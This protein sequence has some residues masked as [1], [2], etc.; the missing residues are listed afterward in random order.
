MSDSDDFEG[1]GFSGNYYDVDVNG[2]VTFGRNVSIANELSGDGS[3]T[4]T[5]QIA[6]TGIVAGDDAGNGTLSVTY[7]W[8]T[9]VAGTILAGTYL[10]LTLVG[11][12]SGFVSGSGRGYNYRYSNAGTY[13]LS[14]GTTTVTG[15]FALSVV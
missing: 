5:S 1:S 6:G 9:D 2:I 10:N 14:A 12:Q 11:D 13:K 15:N 4:F 3:A 8:N 7:D